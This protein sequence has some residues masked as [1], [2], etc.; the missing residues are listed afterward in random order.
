MEDMKSVS[1][2]TSTHS[3]PKSFLFSTPIVKSVDCNLENIPDDFHYRNDRR[4][5]VNA[6]SV[7]F[8]GEQ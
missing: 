1:S 7:A 3:L 4:D 8:K 6:R 5:S 2:P